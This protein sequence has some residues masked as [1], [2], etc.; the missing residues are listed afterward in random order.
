MMNYKCDSINYNISYYYK[1]NKIEVETYS[2][3]NI[4]LSKY[5]Y[6]IE[7]NVLDCLYGECQNYEDDINYILGKYQ[8]ILTIL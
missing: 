3:A 4:L 8:E 5:K 7:N 2:T 6:T 1:K